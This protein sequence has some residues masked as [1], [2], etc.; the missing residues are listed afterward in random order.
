MTPSI[1]AYLIEEQ[2]CQMLSRSYFKRR[3]LRLFEEVAP[4]EEAEE[5][6]ERRQQ[7]QQQQQQRD[8]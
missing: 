5:E 6:E 8:E 7:Q 4:G 2:S 3:S 1:C